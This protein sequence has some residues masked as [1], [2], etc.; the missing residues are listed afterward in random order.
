MCY[1]L[2]SFYLSTGLLCLSY[3]LFTPIPSPAPYLVR[4]MCYF[5]PCHNLFPRPKRCRGSFSFSSVLFT[6]FF[7]LST[8]RVLHF[9]HLS[10]CLWQHWANHLHIRSNVY[11]CKSIFSSPFYVYTAKKFPGME[12]LPPL[13]SCHLPCR[14]CVACHHKNRRRFL[15]L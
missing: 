6:D 3:F 7:H 5:T 8:S 2:T 15:V 1:F 10:D 13:I 4:F 9:I 14:L 11:H 12:G